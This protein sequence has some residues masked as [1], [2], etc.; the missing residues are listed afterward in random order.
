MRSTVMRAERAAATLMAW[1]RASS[2]RA[3]P[4]RGTTT[5]RREACGA[6]GPVTAARTMSIGLGIVCS[7][8][9]VTLPITQREMPPRPW[10]HITTN[11]SGSA[12]A[13]ARWYRGGAPLGSYAD[14]EAGGFQPLAGR[15]Q[16]G[17]D[18][19][20]GVL[21]QLRDDLPVLRPQQAGGQNVESLH[22]FNRRGQGGGNQL[23]VREGL[24]RQFRTVQRHDYFEYIDQSSDLH[25]RRGPG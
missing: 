1:G 15:F 13:W 21:V 22:Q 18:A 14:G 5:D 10:V 20:L 11:A 9:S 2:D 4:S 19:F 8:L 6:A 25:S 12:P 17:G 3:E 16:S 7:T 24:F 23:G